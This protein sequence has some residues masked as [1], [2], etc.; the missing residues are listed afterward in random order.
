MAMFG[1]A[2]IAMAT[3]VGL[4]GLG[5]PIGTHL[6]LAFSAV[7]VLSLTRASTSQD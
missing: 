7:I 3:L 1:G 5:G 6:L 4:A 2:L